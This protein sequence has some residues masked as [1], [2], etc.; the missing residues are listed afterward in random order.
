MKSRESPEIAYLFRL[1]FTAGRSSEALPGKVFS[2]KTAL[3]H[4]ETAVKL[5]KI[6][7]TNL[8]TA[9]LETAVR[10]SLGL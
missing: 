5:S 3:K 8:Q 2:T 4:R 1:I 6:I 10:L 9:A 7:G